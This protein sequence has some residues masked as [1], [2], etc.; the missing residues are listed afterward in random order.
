M[1]LVRWKRFTWNLT[2]L[3]PLAHKMP[4]SLQVR[5]A[6]RDEEK[7]VTPLVIR[8]FTLDSTWGDTLKIFRERLELGMHAAFHREDV[9]AIVVVHGSRIIAAS[10]LST[11]E[12]AE[13]H[14][15]TG[16]CVLPE[17]TNRG[18]GSAL[19]HFSLVQLREA[20]L[21]TAHAV[22]KDNVP[23]AKFVYSKFGSTAAAHEYE[24]LLAG[25]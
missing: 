16:P 1:K 20:G 19:L 8:A 21:T 3:A 22:T 7:D 6:S 2:T 4:E 23:A 18:T 13:S 5:P 15:L 9:P 25:S 14:L 11:E 10:V 12:D 17:Y 24:P